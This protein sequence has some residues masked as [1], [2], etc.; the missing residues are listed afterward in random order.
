MAAKIVD[1]STQ[2]HIEDEH[3]QIAIHCE[4]ITCR[5]NVEGTCKLFNP[6]DGDNLHSLDEF[7]QCK[8]FFRP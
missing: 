7:G 6:I 1:N 5:S 3:V 4:A 8:D 2:R